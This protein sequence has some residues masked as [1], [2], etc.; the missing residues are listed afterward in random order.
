MFLTGWLCLALFIGTAL[1]GLFRKKLGKSWFKIHRV[2]AII[3]CIMVVLHI[4]VNIESLTSYRKRVAAIEIE[5]IDTSQIPDGVYVGECD[6]T[7]IYVKVAVTVKSGEITDVE[8]LEHR[9]T[10]HG[11]PA[12]RV[13]QDIVDEQRIDIDIVA[14]ATNSSLVIEK[15][16]YNALYYREAAQ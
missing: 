13:A 12:E 11:K 14:G 4:A 1:S 9:S 16:V 2:T 6:V 10:E 3:A 5:E 8:I 7:F 15:A